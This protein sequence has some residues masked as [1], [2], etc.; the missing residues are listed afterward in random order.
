MLLRL[1]M[2]DDIDGI[3]VTK[4]NSMDELQGKNYIEDSY[5]YYNQKCKYFKEDKTNTRK[6]L[7]RQSAGISNEKL[8]PIKDTNSP[9]LLFEKTKPYLKVS[10]LNF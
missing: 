8:R 2:V 3:D 9:S 1:K 6:L 4:I 7:S 10:F 5:L